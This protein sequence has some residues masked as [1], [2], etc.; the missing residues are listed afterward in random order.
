MNTWVSHILRC[1]VPEGSENDG[2]SGSWYP[3]AIIIGPRGGSRIALSLLPVLEGT[4]L[5]VV[6][7]GHDT[8]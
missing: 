2:S 7:H 1:Q 8:S 4:T 3:L 5:R 6:I